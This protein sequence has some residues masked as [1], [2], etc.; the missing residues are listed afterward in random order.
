M[1]YYVIIYFILQCNN[2]EALCQTSR[3]TNGTPTSLTQS[4]PSAGNQFTSGQTVIATRI[5]VLSPEHDHAVS[6]RRQEEEVGQ[7]LGHE[8]AKWYYERLNNL[9]DFSATHFWPQSHLRIEYIFAAQPDNAIIDEVANNGEAVCAKIKDL[10][11]VKELWFEV[12]YQTG[13]RGTLNPHGLAQIMV[14]GV[15]YDFNSKLPVGVFEQMFGLMKDI[16]DHQNFK[17]KYT[18]IRLRE[19]AKLALENSPPEM[20]DS[21]LVG[22]VEEVD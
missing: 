7:R 10:R 12:N 6:L 20:T 1:L 11:A 18:V 14:C 9:T 4:H 19:G 13:I 22:I 16:S 15:L 21:S 3:A 5:Q 8:F 17:I 2:Q